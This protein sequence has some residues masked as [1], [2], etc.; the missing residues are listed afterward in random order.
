MLCT[1]YASQCAVNLCNTLIYF[2]VNYSIAFNTE[3]TTDDH[4]IIKMQEDTDG[5]TNCWIHFVNVNIVAPNIQ[6]KSCMSSFFIFRY[7]FTYKL[8]WASYHRTISLLL[9]FIA[10]RTHFCR[11]RHLDVRVWNWSSSTDATTYYN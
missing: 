6:N 7:G 8:H 10:L 5:V 1:D 2:V 4:C 9:H 11:P 3:I